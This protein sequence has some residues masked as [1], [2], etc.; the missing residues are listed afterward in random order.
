[1]SERTSPPHASG[2]APGSTAKA[3]V[4][5]EGSAAQ[6][7]PTDTTPPA[8]ATS[9]PSS[10]ETIGEAKAGEAVVGSADAA[11]VESPESPE[12]VETPEQE[13]DRLRSEVS[14]LRVRNEELEHVRR[15]RPVFSLARGSSGR[16]IVSTV[17]VVLAVVLTPLSVLSVWA[18][19]TLT[20]TNQ[21]VTT[22]APL[23]TNPSIQ[24][25][26][27]TRVTNEIYQNVDVPGLVHEVLPAQLAQLSGPL[28]AAVKSFIGNAV[29]SVVHSP[30]FA[31]I[32]TEANRAAHQQLV[33]AL[34]GTSSAGLS[35][36]N[37]QVHLNLEKLVAQVKQQLSSAGLTAVNK[38]PTNRLQGT[39]VLFT[40]TAV[41]RA[42]WGFRAL[43]TMGDWLPFVALAFFLVGVWLARNRRRALVGGA[44]GIVVA[45]LIFGGAVA[46][47]RSYYVNHLPASVS[48]DAVTAALDIVMRFLR[49][50]FW[51]MVA[52]GALVA[53][54]GIVAGPSAVARGV[55]EGSSSGMGWLGDRAERARILPTRV[56]TFVAPHRHWWEAGVVVVAVLVLFF[57]RGRTVAVELW[58]AFFAVIAL[59]L[60]ELVGRRNERNVLGPAA[61]Q[62]AAVLAAGGPSMAAEAPPA[63]EPIAGPPS[64]EPPITPETPTGPKPPTTTAGGGLTRRSAA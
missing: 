52:L 62:P 59:L 29:S 41:T 38:I 2:T 12:S 64:P 6:A 54:A 40:S 11:A 25:A 45:M 24:A 46:L 14:A 51:A 49:Q 57:W 1:M 61:A 22:V 44:I 21:Y 42:Q 39:F 47:A 10:L 27:T 13:A 30:K 37:G 3:A 28:T 7:P 15:R 63:A 16:R 23:A 18:K 31:T 9:P 53:V 48:R 20:D 56:R 34:T 60:V 55:R 19:N 58:T 36:K 4:P 50:A 26:V 35:V 32:W 33:G 5:A 8:D 43:Q 17:L